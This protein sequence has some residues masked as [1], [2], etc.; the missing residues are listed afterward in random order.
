MKLKDQVISLDL[1][2]KLKKAGVKEN[3]LYVYFDEGNSYTLRDWNE[4]A[5]PSIVY[6]KAPIFPAYTVAELGEMLPD[7]HFCFYKHEGGYLFSING[8][9]D[10]IFI[11]EAEA[12]GELLLHLIKHNLIKL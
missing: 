9:A 3:S 5:S 4:L 1:A 2:K 12:R 7:K 10:R 11:N 8:N 6:P